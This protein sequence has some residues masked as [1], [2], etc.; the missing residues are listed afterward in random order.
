MNKTNKPELQTQWIKSFLGHY[1]LK[2]EQ[3]GLMLR[4]AEIKMPT[5]P[6]SNHFKALIYISFESKNKY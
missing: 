5:N 3:P 1:E 4:A 2:R 6:S